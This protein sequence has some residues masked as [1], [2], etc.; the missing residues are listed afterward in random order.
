M[1]LGRPD[2][3]NTASLTCR[4]AFGRGVKAKVHVEAQWL[5]LIPTDLEGLAHK[6]HG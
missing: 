6:V 3:P 5:D 1:G 2:L 4:G